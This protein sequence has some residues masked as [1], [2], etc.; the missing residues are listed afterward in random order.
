MVTMRTRLAPTPS[1]YL[2]VGNG[3]SFV[4]TWLWARASG[5][6]IVLRIDDL[7][8]ARYRSEF[9]QDIFDSLQWLGLDYDEGPRSVKELENSYS[10]RHHLGEYLA[11]LESLRGK[12]ATGAVADRASADARLVYACDC[13]R[14]RLRGSGG[15]YDGHCRDAGLDMDMPDRALRMRIPGSP[16]RVQDALE[17]DVDVA[18]SSEMG[19]FVLQRR[20]GL[21]AYHLASVVDDIRLGITHV[22]RG[23][24]LLASSAAQLHLASCLG[25]D[26]F[27]RLT[28]CHHGWI[29]GADGGKLS[30]SA[31]SL[32]L[33]QIASMPDG[34]E[35]LL[36]FYAA[37]MGLSITS[38]RRLS[39]L[40][41]GFNPQKI[42]RRDWM[43]SQVPP[44][45]P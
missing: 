41:T 11:A 40:L 36:R 26:D 39:E 25:L 32:A 33:K 30:K 14:K 27:S 24:D 28:L 6:R 38:P 2:H 45:G 20:D 13:S 7:D 35:T 4:L 8:A 42:P 22:V 10:Q 21:P 23:R 43:W 9:A 3:F 17:G 1:G 19:D 5:G 37:C 44:M 15:V 31:G 29:T 34:R 12:A 18:L 16:V